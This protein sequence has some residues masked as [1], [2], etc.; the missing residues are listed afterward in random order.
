MNEVSFAFRKHLSRRTLLRSAGVALALPWLDAMTPA[1]AGA[2]AHSP[3]R[4]VAISNALGFHGPY[5]FPEQP[6]HNYAPPRYLQEIADLQNDFTVCSGVSHPHVGGGHKAEAC[7][8]SAAPFGG[9]NFRNTISLDQYMAKH[10]GGQTRFPSLVLNTK[11]TSS[12]SYTENGSMISAEDSPLRLFNRLFVPDSP[13]A[14][15]RN[16]R[17]LQQGRSILDTVAGEAE[18]MRSRVGGGD[19]QKLDAYFTSVR[20]LE[21][22]LVANEAWA[23]KPKPAIK[24]EPP[25]PLDGKDILLRQKVMLDVVYLALQTD[26]TRFIT[27]HTNGG[28]EV[29]PLPGVQEGY[30]SL[31]HHGLDASKIEQLALIEA[32]Q[33]AAWGAFVR[34]LKETSE[35]TGSMLDHTMILLTS[36]LGNASA[37]DNKNMPVLFAGGRFR[38]GQHLAFDRQNNY[39]L[40]NLYVNCLQE[41]GLETDQFATSTGTMTGLD[42]VETA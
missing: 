15:A 40:P 42:R 11:G 28:G 19:R 25:A 13:E 14:Q 16:V 32:A 36:N 41:L 35:D 30:H 2:A 34:K 6:G 8:L 23:Q 1:F 37:H 10:L 4:F 26:S 24:A 5:L 22:C 9:G 3:R 27:L 29:I 18:S 7:I 12:P 33:V 31:S 38:H 39:P 17:R 20:E 21:Q